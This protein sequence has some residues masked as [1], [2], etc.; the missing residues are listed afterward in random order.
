MLLPNLDVLQVS[1]MEARN[2]ITAR[3]MILDDHW[4]LT[5]MNGESRYQKPPLPP[6]I[7][8]I[9]G[10]LF[11]HKSIFAMRLPAIIM[12]TILVCY[13]FYL[14]RS[15]LKS[16]THALINALVALSSFYI[17]GITFEAPSD[18]FTHA[19]M[20]I[21]IYCLY[22]FFKTEKK[23][24]PYALTA[25]FWIGLSILSKGP[26]SLYALLLPFLIAYG[27]TY[28][29]NAKGK[30]WAIFSLSVLALLIG[31]SWYLYIRSADPEIFLATAT[32]ETGNWTSYNRRPFYYYWSFFTQSGLW[33]IPAFISL[34]YPYLKK[35]VSNYKAYK[36]SFLWTLLAVVLLSIIPEKKSR[37]LMPVLIPL[38]IT[39]GF[40][41]E[42]LFRKFKSLKDRRETFPV[43]FNFG[44]IGLLGLIIPI[45]I[46]I[47]FK[48]EIKTNW[49]QFT[50]FSAALVSIGFA[51][52][53][54]LKQKSIRQVFILSIAF[55]LA[56]ITFGLPLYKSFTSTNYKPITS[57]LSETKDKQL[58]VYGFNYISPETIWQFGDK[59]P[60]I[61]SKNGKLLFP[62][63]SSFGMLAGNISP[64]DEALLKERY[65][66]E[67]IRQYDLNKVSKNSKQYNSRLLSNYY[68]ISKK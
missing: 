5:T 1:I 15:I 61:K 55:F 8:A 45:L 39:I 2:F 43:Y 12:L 31:S 48:T 25:G 26:V 4:L 65:T 56:I 67:L 32:K 41:I 6:W 51:L 62:I 59:I 35:R 47:F 10:L 66:V 23:Y 28:K 49:V 60:A 22:K 57:L 58:K 36:F 11:G 40:Y 16:R 9:S 21:A 29:F 19:F 68:I 3:E 24:W 44:L 50:L 37:Y 14:S 30:G 18:I 17:V 63:E 54:K 13:V 33:T 42:Y 34:L 20:C 27:I 38:S 53:L 7:A 52:L 46:F 64:K